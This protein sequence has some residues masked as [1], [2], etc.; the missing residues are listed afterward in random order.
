[1]SYICE[2]NLSRVSMMKT[3]ELEVELVEELVPVG[4]F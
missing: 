3:L 4:P 1:M 2:L